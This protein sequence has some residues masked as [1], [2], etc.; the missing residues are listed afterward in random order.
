MSNSSFLS[1]GVFMFHKKYLMHLK[2]QNLLL[3][4]VCVSLL[5]QK[6]RRV[7]RNISVHI[8]SS[9]IRRLQ[10]RQVGVLAIT[11]KLLLLTDL[12]QSLDPRWFVEEAPAD[13]L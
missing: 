4:T 2:N 6:E 3:L 5:Q 13:H 11:S 10:R 8:S 7:Y 12:W 1:F 9:V